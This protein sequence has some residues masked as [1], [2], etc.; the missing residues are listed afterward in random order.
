VSTAIAAQIMP[1]ITQEMAQA[2]K[3]MKRVFGYDSFREGQEDVIAAV[4][5]GAMSLP[6]CPPD[7]ANRCATNCPLWWRSG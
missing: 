5:G 4:L 1:D 7:R 3:V 2:R 6:S